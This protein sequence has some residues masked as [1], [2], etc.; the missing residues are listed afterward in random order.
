MADENNVVRCFNPDCRRDLGRL[1]HDDAGIDFLQVGGLLLREAH[2]ICIQCGT[3]FHWS[4]RDV[5]FEKLIGR[6]LK[7]RNPV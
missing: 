4:V 2:G 7:G 5:M 1:V 6:L 3:P